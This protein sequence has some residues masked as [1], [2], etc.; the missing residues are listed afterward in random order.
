MRCEYNQLVAPGYA[1][2]TYCHHLNVYLVL[3]GL[4]GSIACVVAILMRMRGKTSGE[5]KQNQVS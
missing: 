1:I 2:D 4:N 3:C 5:V